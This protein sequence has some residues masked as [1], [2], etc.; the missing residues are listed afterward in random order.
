MVVCPLVSALAWPQ[1]CAT[2]RPT[3]RHFVKIVKSCSK[4]PKTCKSVKTESRKIFAIPVRSSYTE[5]EESK[6]GTLELFMH[7]Y[8]RNDSQ[9]GMKNTFHSLH[10]ML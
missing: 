3:D 4:Y 1:N 10:L 9:Y 8:G 7:G 6:S 5:I 2:Y